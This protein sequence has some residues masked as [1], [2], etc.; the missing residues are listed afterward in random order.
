M[1]FHTSSERYDS[2]S[3]DTR[4]TERVARTNG[5]RQTSEHEHPEPPQN[6]TI[7]G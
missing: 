4:A 1:L 7:E 5:E 6:P 3:D 2:P